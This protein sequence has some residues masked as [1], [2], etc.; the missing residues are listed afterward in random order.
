M[1]KVFN[2]HDLLDQ[3]EHGAGCPVDII[4]G[5][6]A[7]EGGGPGPGACVECA[8]V[9]EFGSHTA[10]ALP[11]QMR[12][13]GSLAAFPC[14][15]LGAAS[16]FYLPYLSGP[17]FG[18]NRCTCIKFLEPRH[19]S[20]WTER[21]Q[22]V[23]QPG[24]KWAFFNGLGYNTWENVWGSW[25]GVSPRD[26]ETIRRVFSILRTFANATASCEY[27][28]FYPGAKVSQHREYAQ[29]PH[30]R[31]AN[32]APAAAGGV[33]LAATL[34]PGD[35]MVLLTAIN[36]GAGPIGPYTVTLNTTAHLKGSSASHVDGDA[37][38]AG[39]GTWMFFD[40]WRGQPITP[41]LSSLSPVEIV[42]SAESNDAYAS[43][44]AVRPAIASSPYFVRFLQKMQ[45][46]SKSLIDSYSAL[47]ATAINSTFATN[48]MPARSTNGSRSTYNKYSTR[49]N[50]T[51]VS[52]PEIRNFSFKWHTM[53]S[54][55][56][57]EP[58]YPVPTASPPGS[59]KQ[60][61]AMGAFRYHC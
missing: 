24:L 6:W 42:L 41:T 3:P 12:L 47:P 51:M 15:Y 40:L 2:G 20:E 26:G 4:L 16:H 9:S 57:L 8:K 18:L 55:T 11:I 44:A 23:R 37:V 43:V 53:I 61:M 49:T 35:D 1:G 48:T 32:A 52:I 14:P 50:R 58:V 10:H 59:S 17:S 30:R 45:L 13:G 38:S 31:T 33:D 21:H 34:F 46:L 7:G 29:N 60:T 5:G 56:H 28:P 27:R 39:D 25:N 22:T 19:T 54:E 36:Q